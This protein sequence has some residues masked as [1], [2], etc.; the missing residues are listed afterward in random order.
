MLTLIKNTQ[1]ERKT[2]KMETT[3]TPKTPKTV[4]NQK[5]NQ[6]PKKA[7]AWSVLLVVIFLVM[8][9]TK[10]V[11][12]PEK[13]A[14]V[15]ES[16]APAI[17]EGPTVEELQ[18]KLAKAEADAK[19]EAKAKADTAAAIRDRDK[20][21]E[22]QRTETLKVREL[23]SKIESE[24]KAKAEAAAIEAAKPKVPAEEAVLVGKKVWLIGN[25]EHN[26]FDANMV[27][28]KGPEKVHP[29]VEG[30]GI[31]KEGLYPVLAPDGNPLKDTGAPVN[32]K[33]AKVLSVKTKRGFEKYW[34]IQ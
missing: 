23:M 19:A 12:F 2:R 21:L 11:F 3:E 4:K 28:R 33:G 13:A 20:E 10:A 18:L 9:G 31:H 5:T 7:L 30:K 15:V 8:W 17:K 22:T 16:V 24:A 34:F 1:T 32:L 25:G 6:T 29:F 26:D 14:P 27:P